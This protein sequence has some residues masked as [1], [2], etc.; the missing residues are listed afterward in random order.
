MFKNFKN[1]GISLFTIIFLLLQVNVVLAHGGED[2]SHEEEKPT[3][4]VNT[5]TIGSKLFNSEKVEV[6]IKYPELHTNIEAPFQVF[7]TDFKT[8]KPVN[9]ANVSLYFESEDSNISPIK[10]QAV[11]SNVA[12]VYQ[13]NVN[14]EKNSIYRMLLGITKEEIDESFSI[15]ELIVENNTVVTTSTENIFKNWLL[16]ALLLL[17]AILLITAIYLFTTKTKTLTVKDAA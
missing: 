10:L 13:V 5:E 14:F 12:G 11:E 7:V 16:P 15:E 2:H 17:M 3:A 8:N 9:N 4:V 1:I 6:M